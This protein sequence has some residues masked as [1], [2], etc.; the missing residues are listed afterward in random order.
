MQ[1]AKH[2]I[3]FFEKLCDVEAALNLSLPVYQEVYHNLVEKPAA[4]SIALEVLVSSTL[5]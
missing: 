1:L 2:F 3:T 4:L 5:L